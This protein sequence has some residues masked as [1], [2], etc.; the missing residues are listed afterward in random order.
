[1]LLSIVIGA[2]AIVGLFTVVVA[3]FFAFAYLWMLYEAKR[4]NDQ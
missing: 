3:A 4:E 2:L 1:M